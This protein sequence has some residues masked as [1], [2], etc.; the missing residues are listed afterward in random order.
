MAYGGF[1]RLIKGRAGGRGS[2][3]ASQGFRRGEDNGGGTVA[4]APRV[5]LEAIVLVLDT[6]TPIQAYAVIARLALPFAV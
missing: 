1:G 5:E 2:R 6:A 4:S 3:M